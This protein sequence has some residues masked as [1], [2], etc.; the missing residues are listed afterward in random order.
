MSWQWDGEQAEK[1]FGFY[2]PEVGEVPLIATHVFYIDMDE[3]MCLKDGIKFFNER[4]NKTAAFAKELN[5]RGFKILRHTD[6]GLV[7]LPDVDG[8][9]RAVY[10]DGFEVNSAGNF[11][12]EP[13]LIEEYHDAN[14]FGICHI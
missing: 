7:N 8:R 10:R 13:N 1:I 5:R 11:V 9:F 14:S 4:L 2:K 3:A 6:F 12:D